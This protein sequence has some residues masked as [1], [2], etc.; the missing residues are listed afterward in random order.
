MTME[1]RTSEP[2][3]RRRE[4]HVVLGKRLEV[5]E[6]IRA[7][8]ISRDEAAA[9]LDVSIQ[10]VYRWQ[11]MHATD[12]IVSLGRPDGRAATHEESA[13]LARRRRLVRLLRSVDAS[14]R[15]LHSQ[16]VATTRTARGTP[17]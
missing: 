8:K 16:L 1:S 3:A 17:S 6:L 4:R 14:L 2:R 10:E 15:H 13:L 11:S 12:H 7:G 9:L 5:L